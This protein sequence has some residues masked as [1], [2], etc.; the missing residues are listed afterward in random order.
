MTVLGPSRS[1]NVTFR[2]SQFPHDRL[3]LQQGNDIIVFEPSMIEE[4][5][6]AMQKGSEAL[7]LHL[8]EIPHA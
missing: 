3:I 4:A 2:I 7:A 6:R 1:E 5:R 8:K